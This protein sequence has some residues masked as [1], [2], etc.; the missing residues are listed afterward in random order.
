MRTKTMTTATATKAMMGTSQAYGGR[1]RGRRGG[2]Y[3]RA[4]AERQ[5]SSSMARRPLALIVA[6]FV[7]QP[8]LGWALQSAVGRDASC[9]GHVCACKAARH[10]PP[11][12]VAAKPCH[13]APAPRLTMSAACSHGDEFAPPAAFRAGIVPVAPG[14]PPV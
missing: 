14:L 8:S 5:W 1:G 13:E 2:L 11:R 4:R 6:L 10:C 9:T 7:A 12:N 3:M